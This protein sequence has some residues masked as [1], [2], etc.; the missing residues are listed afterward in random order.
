MPFFCLLLCFVLKYTI[1]YLLR[2]HHKQI[3]RLMKLCYVMKAT[4]N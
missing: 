2:L 1:L 3:I 4:K